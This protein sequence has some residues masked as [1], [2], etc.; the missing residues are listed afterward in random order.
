MPRKNPNIYQT[1]SLYKCYVNM[2]LICAL[3]KS[4]TRALYFIVDPPNATYMRQW[5]GSALAQVMARRLFSAKSLPESML[6]YF[7]LDH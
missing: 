6:T 2:T 4:L 7:Q 1:Q 5:T 3:N